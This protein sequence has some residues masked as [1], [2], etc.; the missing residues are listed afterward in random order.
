[1]VEGERE[2]SMTAFTYAPL[3]SHAE[4]SDFSCASRPWLPKDSEPEVFALYIVALSETRREIG[5]RRRN[6]FSP[7]GGRTPVR[8]KW[9]GAKLVE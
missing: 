9:L 5:C 2:I 1:M 3:Q 7:F 6:P 4:S 8:P